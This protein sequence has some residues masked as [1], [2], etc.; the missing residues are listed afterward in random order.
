[1]SRRA[2][3]EKLSLRAYEFVDYKFRSK[4]SKRVRRRLRRI[5]KRRNVRF[6]EEKHDG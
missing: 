4:A 3:P 5:A 2:T 6:L 1:M